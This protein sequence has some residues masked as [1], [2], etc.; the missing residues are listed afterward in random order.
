MPVESTG[1]GIH[2]GRE[3][4]VSPR[5]NAY[6]PY[7]SLPAFGQFADD[8]LAL[9]RCRMP[10]YN[11]IPHL[12]DLLGLHV[13]LYKL[14]CAQMWASP[15]ARS[16]SVL[17]IIAPRRTTIRDLA[18]ETYLAN[19]LRSREAIDAYLREVVNQSPEWTSALQ[20]ADA[21]AEAYRVLRSKV[22]WPDADM[23]EYTGPETPDG[24][25]GALQSAAH[26][27]H[28]GHLANVHARYAHEIGLA[29]RRGTRRV[30]YA[31]NDQILRSLVFANVE[32]RMEFQQF[33]A[34]LHQRYGF[35]IGHR[36]AGTSSIRARV[37]R[38]RSP[39]TPAGWNCVWRV[40]ACSGV[41][42]MPAPTSRTPTRGRGNMDALD[43]I[44]RSRGGLP[45]T[46]HRH[47]RPGGWDPT[48]PPRSAHRRR[49]PPSAAGSSDRPRW[50][51]PSASA[52]RAILVPPMASPKKSSPTSGR[53]TGGTPHATGRCSSSRTR[54]TTKGSHCVTSRR[55]AARNCSASRPSGWASSRRGSA[56][57][58]SRLPYFEK[59]L[60][61]LQDAKPV[62][63]E[64]FAAYVLTT[65]QAID[66]Q[67][68]PLI[69]ALGWAFPILRIPRDSAYFEAIPEKFRTHASRWK[70]LYQQG[71]NKRAAYLIKTTPTQQPISPE[72]LQEMWQRVA[73]AVPPLHHPAVEAFI[74]A[75]GKWCPE[76]EA[77]AALEWERDN[78]KAL[79][80][81][82][83][84]RRESLG[85]TT[86]DFYEGDLPDTLTAD[87]QGYLPAARCA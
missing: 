32:R 82:L 24:L 12:V 61:G 84:A 47:R 72:Q 3:R 18:T 62:S 8:W 2:A 64:T 34:V 70:R 1:A 22:A 35:V 58:T 9:L 33:L 4:D 79:F 56:S 31:P 63:L 46:R 21:F 36:Q 13:L 86:L 74:A 77:L 54:T 29:S 51:Q 52:F 19:N 23:G 78:V 20:Q 68:L 14:R 10:G 17:E 65:R 27:R 11:I 48:L 81:G 60:K 25:R 16:N 28:D 83:R 44:G 55:S 38:S 67:G 75:P 85:Q 26:R 73:D 76:A 30:R 5:A 40:S 42:P 87:E 15:R 57:Q 41:S 6:L 43:L 69:N 45:D 59:A 71:F 37:T 39:T 50:P 80:D 53:R 7:R 49:C 66:V